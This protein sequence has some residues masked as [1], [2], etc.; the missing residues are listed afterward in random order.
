MISGLPSTILPSV[1]KEIWPFLEGFAD[2]SRERWTADSLWS[3][4]MECDKQAWM[5]GDWQAVCITSVTEYAIH[6]EACS[7]IRRHE[8]QEELDETLTAWAKELGKDRIFAL[9]RPGWAKYGN[10]RGYREIHREFVKE[11]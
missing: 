7:G 3:A 11:L 8:W 2:R 1:Q 9:A 5:V 4:L 10:K 6:I